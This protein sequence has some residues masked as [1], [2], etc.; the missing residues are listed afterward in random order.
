[1]IYR[2]WQIHTQGCSH[3]NPDCKHWWKYREHLLCPLRVSRLMPPSRAAG[4]EQSNSAGFVV[5]CGAAASSHRSNLMAA[6][7][8]CPLHLMCCRGAMV[9]PCFN[10]TALYVKFIP[11]MGPERNMR[12]A[13]NIIG[14][15]SFE[16]KKH[17]GD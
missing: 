9:H 11:L 13:M 1:M 12:Q 7:C 14:K 8:K 10:W 6:L 17:F 3:T 4:Q 2:Q 15:H 5:L 16:W